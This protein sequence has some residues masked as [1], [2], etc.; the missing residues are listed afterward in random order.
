[1]ARIEHIKWVEAAI[2]T[3]NR[4]FTAHGRMKVGTLHVGYSDGYPRASPEGF[5]R[6]NGSEAGPWTVSINTS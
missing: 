6:V 1:M 4:R 5:V 3:Y 2:L